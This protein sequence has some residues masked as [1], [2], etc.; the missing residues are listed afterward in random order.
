[1]ASIYRES[2]LL[3]FNGLGIWEGIGFAILIL[4]CPAAMYFGMRGKGKD[5]DSDTKRKDQDIDR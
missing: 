4:L 2:A 5:P 1:M 3:L